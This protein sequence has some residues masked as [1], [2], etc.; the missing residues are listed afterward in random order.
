[1]ILETFTKQPNEVQDYDIDFNEYLTS[2]GGDSITAHVIPLVDGLDIITSTVVN[3]VVK[4]FIG[5]GTAGQKY[6]VTVRVN[7]SG[8]RVREAEIAIKVREY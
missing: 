6:V 3:G 2:M 7:T 8:G 5:G 1:M 4:V